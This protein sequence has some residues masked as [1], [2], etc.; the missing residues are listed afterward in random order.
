MGC[1]R[2]GCAAHLINVFCCHALVLSVLPSPSSRVSKGMRSQLQQLLNPGSIILRVVTC[3]STT[4]CPV[5]VVHS[6][7][8]N[9]I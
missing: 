2:W 4:Q 3:G 8:C 1:T 7:Q 5:L 9:N 6:P